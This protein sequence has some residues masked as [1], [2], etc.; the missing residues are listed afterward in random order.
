MN[1]NADNNNFEDNNATT[2]SLE[3]IKDKNQKK[4]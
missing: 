3:N 2:E 4:I 1:I